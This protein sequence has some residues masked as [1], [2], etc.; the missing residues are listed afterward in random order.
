MIYAKLTSGLAFAFVLLLV[1][2]TSGR[3]FYVANWNLENLFDTE[4]D[5]A[6]E[7][8]EDFT[9]DAPK[10]WT[11][12][13]LE[14]KLE[15]QAK[16]ISKMN[17]GKGPDVLG[18]CEVENRKVLDMLAAKLARLGRNYEI[19]HKD[20]PS[21]RGIDCALIYDAKVFQLVDHKFHFIDANKTRDIVEAKLRHD[22]ADLY[23]FM[24]HWP[25]RGNDEWERC[26]A[27]T[28]LRKR[29]DAILAAEPKADFVLLGD[30]NDESDNVSMT[31]FLLVESKPENLPAGALFDTAAHIRAEGKG[32]F[33]YENK[34]D[35]LDHIIIS[36]GL[37]D[38]AGY[39]WKPNSTERVDFPELIFKPNFPG[40]I[41]RP[42]SSY[43]RDKFFEKGY[44]DHL[45]V[46]C[47]IVQ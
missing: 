39:H 19:I 16:I 25:S 18:V 2:S 35:L 43:N 24:N 13:R 47:I 33:V 45:P 26:L 6:V 37:L 17:V 27:A 32:T 11:R 44:S 29:L 12:E 20:S 22:G 31:K 42:N 38:S 3:D 34:W 15:N 30:F 36:P 41:E 7:G 5:T 8:D 10:K 1:A 9:P 28:V 46:G 14:I 23:V 21:D 40:A 4:D